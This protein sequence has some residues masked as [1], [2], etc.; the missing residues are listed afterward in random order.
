MGITFRK[1]ILES[2]LLNP[3]KNFE[4]DTKITE[5][6]YDPLT[7]RNCRITE[8]HVSPVTGKADL[9]E[10]IEKSKNCFFCADKVE[11][12]TPKLPPEMSSDERIKIGEA[13]LFPN[14]SAYGKY[15]SVCI[16][17]REHFTEL[18]GLTP[19]LV[20][21]NL[22]AHQRYVQLVADYDPSVE[23]CSINANYLP[24]AG[25]SLFHPHTQSTIDPMPTNM[26]RDL[27]ACSQSYYEKNR[28]VFW[29]DLVQAEK[30]QNERYLGSIGNTAWLVSYAPIGFY[31]VQ[32]VVLG[33]SSLAQM[34]SADIEGMGTGISKVLRYYS[35]KN[36]NSFN[37][38]VYSGPLRGSDSFRVCIRIINRSNFEPYY[39][40][41][42]TYF[43]RL[44]LE[45][46]MD[47][48]PEETAAEMRPYF[49]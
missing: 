3:L 2:R 12:V 45:G 49:T 8:P 24:S 38:V 44:H 48:R 25:S 4:L 10:L 18:G 42:A 37:F 33:H 16:Y 15:S 31:E 27:V 1:D 23:Y 20:G 21:N 40:S 7:G 46:M 6:R 29:L 36:F 32:G 22:K 39:R 34:T 30:D 41:D 28:S 26:Q 19:E 5:I 11:K 14:L 35:D 9:S 43:E 13:V 17:S 47:T